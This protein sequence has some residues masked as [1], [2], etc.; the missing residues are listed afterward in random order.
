MGAARD[1]QTMGKHQVGHV[2]ELRKCS[3]RTVM[4]HLRE[5]A[6]QQR[7]IMRRRHTAT[8]AAIVSWRCKRSWRRSALCARCGH[9]W[10][11]LQLPGLLLRHCAAEGWT[12]PR[13]TGMLR[14]VGCGD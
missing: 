14:T 12:A 2:Q 8:A 7:V 13:S 4:A 9:R 3:S 5:R 11:G 6:A 1:K 10:G